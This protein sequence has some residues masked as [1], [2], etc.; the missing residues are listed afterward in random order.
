MA[1]KGIKFAHCCLS[2]EGIVS[3]VLIHNKEIKYGPSRW[4]QTDC[5]QF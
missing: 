4:V 5:D 2:R 1:N 3:G